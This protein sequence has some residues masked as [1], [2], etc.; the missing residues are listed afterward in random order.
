M[1]IQR[2]QTIYFFLSA[3]V[4][5]VLYFLPFAAKPGDEFF[6]KEEI[7]TL[8]LTVIPAAL[9]LI[10]I[11][12]YKNRR[13][14]MRIARIAGIFIFALMLYLLYM[15]YSEFKNEINIRPAY[16]IPPLALILNYLGISKVRKDEKLVKSTD[17]LR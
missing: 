2:I 15:Y 9:A 8:L 4:L 12:L 1:M 6:V 16:F 11:F 7:P 10:V 13:L 3:L 17:R 5:G 14:Q